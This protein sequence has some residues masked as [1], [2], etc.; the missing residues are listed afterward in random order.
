MKI[1]KMII[2]NVL[3]RSNGLNFFL[4]VSSM[5]KAGN[6]FTARKIPEFPRKSK[7]TYLHDKGC[8]RGYILATCSRDEW[9]KKTEQIT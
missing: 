8:L 2:F 1:Q 3:I 9:V 7:S 5:W 4:L 6:T